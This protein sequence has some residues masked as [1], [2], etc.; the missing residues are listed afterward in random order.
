MIAQYLDYFETLASNHPLILHDEEHGK[1][2]FFS[3][4]F[5]EVLLGAFKNGIRE[6]GIALYAFNYLSDF[7]ERNLEK[8][9][10]GFI[11]MGYYNR[12]QKGS[13]KAMYDLTEAITMQVIAT[14]QHDSDQMH[15]LWLDSLQHLDKFNKEPYQYGANADYVG[16]M[17]HFD[18]IHVHNMKNYLA[19]YLAPTI[20]Q[21]PVFT[22]GWIYELEGMAVYKWTQPKT[23]IVIDTSEK[24]GKYKTIKV[25]DILNEW[26]NSLR[27]LSDTFWSI[28]GHQLTLRFTQTQQGTVW[29]AGTADSDRW[30]YDYEADDEG[31]FLIDYAKEITIEGDDIEIHIHNAAGQALEQTAFEY[32]DEPSKI[33]KVWL[34]DWTG[35]N[36]TGT[37]TIIVIQ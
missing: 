15:P 22:E 16:W 26:K 35:D 6:K 18:F 21:S 3:I 7:Q 27:N 28:E 36:A 1:R 20:D 5:G 11:V 10:G 37:I 9:R 29:I 30:T 31:Y 25:Q 33:L 13:L 23:E 12:N 4:N 17:V 2:G 14:L 8:P 24:M 32:A 19:D 34:D